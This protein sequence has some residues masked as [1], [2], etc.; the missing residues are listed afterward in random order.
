MPEQHATYD[1]FLS[2]S[3]Q[4]AATARSLCNALESFG[5]RYL[6][7]RRF[8]IWHDDSS[9]RITASLHSEIDRALKQSNH[10]LVLLSPDAMQSPW[11]ARE[12]Q[13]FVQAHGTDR[14]GLLLTRGSTPWTHD[15]EEP[16][17]TLEPTLSPMLAGGHEPLIVDLRRFRAPDGTLQKSEAFTNTLA[18]VA[19]G[20]ANTAKDDIYGEH[21][22]ALRSRIVLLAVLAV[23]LLAAVIFAFVQA[24][25][26]E[27]S[28]REQQASYA[29][30]SAQRGNGELVALDQAV[31]AAGWGLSLPHHTPGIVAPI[32]ELVVR[33]YGAA[34]PVFMR[35][36]AASIA[37]VGRSH[38][39]AHHGGDAN[40]AIY[41]PDGARVVTASGDCTVCVL[42]PPARDCKAELIR[43]RAQNWAEFAEDGTSLVTAEGSAI[44]AWQPDLH[45]P[46]WEIETSGDSVRRFFRGDELLLTEDGR[47]VQVWNWRRHQ[48]LQTLDG[49]VASIAQDFKTL[50]V[51][52]PPKISV[53]GIGE[54]GALEEHAVLDSIGH[55]TALG[56]SPDGTQV[57]A[58]MLDGQLFVWDVVGKEITYRLQGHSASVNDVTFSK[59][60]LRMVSASSDG[61]ARVWDPSSGALTRTLQQHDPLLSARFS[62]DGLHVLTA[63]SDGAVRLASLVDTESVIDVQSDAPERFPDAQSS[64]S[65]P[66]VALFSR[67]SE[68][69]F[70]IDGNDVLSRWQRDGHSASDMRIEHA[71]AVAETS[72]EEV[73]AITKA[74]ELVRGSGGMKL[75]TGALR[76]AMLSQ[77]GHYAWVA[78]VHG[79]SHL[80]DTESGREPIPSWNT[81]RSA[82]PSLISDAM[83]AIVGDDNSIDLLDNETGALIQHFDKHKGTVLSVALGRQIVS[84]SAD[85]KLLIWD[86]QSGQVQSE[87]KYAASIRRISVTRDGGRALLIDGGHVLH[88]L[89]LSNH[90]ELDA[91]IERESVWD[92]EWSPDGTRFITK[93]RAGKSSLWAVGVREPL[94]QYDTLSSINALSFAP[95]GDH[96][97]VL[98]Y[99]G[100]VFLLPT[101]EQELVRQACALAKREQLA[102]LY[103]EY[104]NN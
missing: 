21:I 32:W 26:T 46:R 68:H 70:V 2:Y 18:T 13:L 69:I 52:L 7:S 39:I 5:R 62:Q 25:A 38:V 44:I 27:R 49:Y 71:L 1:A 30:L 80:L 73:V 40:S 34:D 41:S 29:E 10:L 61:T 22:R 57:V 76:A 92:A 95:N 60:V 37:A 82:M 14:V 15:S 94:A 75:G 4:D 11:V 100:R 91:D 35:A 93:G 43:K 66:R 19:A 45:E 101:S 81:P 104:C 47:H 3:H 42:E 99:D 102:Q 58:G 23:M 67:N 88:L 85:G 31:R 96:A 89:D 9:L 83:T 56:V 55:V 24:R 65:P 17:L 64:N 78:D 59:D 51:Y 28:S 50:A 79:H 103:Q 72:Q 84:S 53:Y 48:R 12:V 86:A 87:R 90:S 36:L 74:G 6:Q 77:S 97:L 20:L 16:S 98:G 63:S 8:R 33:H 54:S